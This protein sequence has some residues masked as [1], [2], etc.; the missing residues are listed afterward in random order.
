M[1][2]VLQHVIRPTKAPYFNAARAVCNTR[3]YTATELQQSYNGA[4]APFINE[5]RAVSDIR[6]IL[7]FIVHYEFRALLLLCCSSV[8]AC[9]HLM[10]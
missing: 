4:V 6:C 1:Q 2:E 3:S 5:A 10:L 8:A 7:K 9:M